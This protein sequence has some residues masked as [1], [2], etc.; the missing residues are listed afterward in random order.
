MRL[1]FVIV[2]YPDLV[3]L[4]RPS[5]GCL[6]QTSE[7][8]SHNGS[9]LFGVQITTETAQYDPQADGLRLRS[10]CVFC[11]NFRV[12]DRAHASREEKRQSHP[13]ICL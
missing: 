5:V 3:T 8:H 13:G 11:F 6:G 7:I 2:K 1:I 12:V 10:R 4:A 9:C